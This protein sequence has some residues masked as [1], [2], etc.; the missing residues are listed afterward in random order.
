MYFA[1]PVTAYDRCVFFG[2]DFGSRLFEQYFKARKSIDYNGYVM[3][4]FDT[5][6]FFTNFFNDNPS[7]VSRMANLM[8]SVIECKYNSKLMSLPKLIVIVP[9]NDII[10]LLSEKDC[11]SSLSKPFSR[12][13]NYIMTE[14]ERAIA[15][16]KDYLP[17][18]CIQDYPYILWIQAPFHDNFTDNSLRYKFNKCLTE[19]VNFHLN[20]S[21]LE[22]KKVWDSKDSNLFIKENQRFTCDGYRSYW[23]AVDRTV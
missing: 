13:L 15:S 4:N 5:V 22:L 19:A 10:K 14:H 18:K 9:D 17:A 23:E 21:T 1:V 3:A 8:N 16:Y 20:M 12:I 6:G 11:F 7:M 2:D